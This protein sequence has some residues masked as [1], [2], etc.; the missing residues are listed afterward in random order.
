M[1]NRNSE[2]RRDPS[3]KRGTRPRT[4]TPPKGA[5]TEIK[6]IPDLQVWS[7]PTLGW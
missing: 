6:E 4:A 1:K 7:T 3:G 2:T 5:V